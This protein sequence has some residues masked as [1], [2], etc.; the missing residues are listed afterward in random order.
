MEY[1]RHSEH[2]GL[3]TKLGF[4]HLHRGHGSTGM[5]AETVDQGENGTT[6]YPI[7]VHT[8]LRTA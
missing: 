4:S 1:Y 3:T 6:C 7:Q 5:S 2:R 8:S